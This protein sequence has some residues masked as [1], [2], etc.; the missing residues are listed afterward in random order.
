M[1]EL[2][3]DEMATLVDKA[4]SSK[5]GIEISVNNVA[6]FKAAWKKYLSTTKELGDDRT[7]QLELRVISMSAIFLVKKERAINGDGRL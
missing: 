1:I 6:H 4:L 5:L 2:T 7:D 3:F